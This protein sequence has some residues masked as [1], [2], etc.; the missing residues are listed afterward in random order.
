M[1]RHTH[2][3]KRDELVCDFCM[4]GNVAF[5]YP[6]DEVL[7]A[8]TPEQS[9]TS[10]GG[11]SACAACAKVVD[12]GDPIALAQHAVSR[13][14]DEL[15]AFAEHCVRSRLAQI[16]QKLLPKLGKKVP[17]TKPEGDDG[18]TLRIVEE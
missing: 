9:A 8:I 1:T 7:V 14:P 3:L 18:V 2:I 6:C 10:I 17:H 11:W 4:G 5:A 15:S 12:K 13:W 16:Y